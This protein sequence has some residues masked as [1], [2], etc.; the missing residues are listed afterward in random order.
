[1]SRLTQ[2]SLGNEAAIFSA[3]ESQHQEASRRRDL[4]PSPRPS[5]GDHRARPDGAQRARGRSGG[6]GRRRPPQE[7]APQDEGNMDPFA[8]EPTWTTHARYARPGK[9]N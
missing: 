8:W 5:E 2:E 4:P 1:M 6:V 3:L 9:R 7:S